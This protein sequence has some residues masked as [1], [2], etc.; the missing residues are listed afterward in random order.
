M[1]GLSKNICFPE[2]SDKMFD[3]SVELVSQTSEP[4]AHVNAFDITS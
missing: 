1:T 2:P 3:D 4:G